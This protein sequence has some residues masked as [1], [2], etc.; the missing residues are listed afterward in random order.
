MAEEAEQDTGAEASGAG[1]DPAA[2]ALALGGASREK[3]DAFLKTRTLS[4]IFK[5]ITC[6]NN[7][8]T[9]AS[10]FAQQ[11]LGVLLRIATGFVGLIVAAGLGFMI[12]NAS[13]S[14]GLLIEPF[15]MP[16][17][18]TQRGMTGEVVAS[19]L[20]DYSVGNAKSNKCHA[21]G[22]DLRQ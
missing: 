15:S 10:P 9:F 22:H 8:S 11:R 13:Q 19:K 3:A 14:N 12:W 17:D 1:V 16:P 7:S 4:L 2:V 18:L 6:A 5:S 20:L 21:P